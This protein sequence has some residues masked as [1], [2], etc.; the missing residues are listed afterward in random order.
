ML[1]SGTCLWYGSPKVSALLTYQMVLL[2][3]IWTILYYLMEAITPFFIHQRLLVFVWLYN[4]F[5]SIMVVNN[6]LILDTGPPQWSFTR[7]W[8]I[9]LSRNLP[10]GGIY[11]STR[12]MLTTYCT[13]GLVSIKDD[14]EGK[15]IFTNDDEIYKLPFKLLHPNYCYWAAPGSLLVWNRGEQHSSMDQLSR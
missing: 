1:G 14:L 6:I 4:I 11:N 3:L 10:C 12:I 13:W 8:C 2:F 9:W 7:A 5:L 15:V